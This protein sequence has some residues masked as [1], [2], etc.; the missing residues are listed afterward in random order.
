[1]S[2]VNLLNKI[3]IHLRSRENADFFNR[4]AMSRGSVPAAVDSVSANHV[5]VAKNQ[6]QCGSCAAFSATSLT[7]TCMLRAN[8]AMDGLDLSEQDLLDCAYNYNDG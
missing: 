6:G 3:F 2:T 5:T 8:A 4:F 1:M 7:E